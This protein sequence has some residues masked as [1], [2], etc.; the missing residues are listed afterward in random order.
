[1]IGCVDGTVHVCKWLVTL[2]SLT[3]YTHVRVCVY[4]TMQ[5]SRTQQLVGTRSAQHHPDLLVQFAVMAHHDLR[6]AVRPALQHQLVWLGVT[7]LADVCQVAVDR[8]LC[9]MKTLNT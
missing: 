6:P 8:P 2:F 7:V 1:M 5:W 4:V 9:L 3:F